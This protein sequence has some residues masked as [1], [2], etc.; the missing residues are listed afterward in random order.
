MKILL[1][2]RTGKNEKTARILAENGFQCIEIA[3][4]KLEATNAG[5]PP[6]LSLPGGANS[7]DCLIVTSAAAFEVIG[8]DFHID[9]DLRIYAVGEAS[10]RAA[11]DVG[12]RNVITGPGNASDLVQMIL[13]DAGDQKLRALYACSS[14]PAF[15]MAKA[16]EN[17]NITLV[18]WPIY[19]TVMTD[20]GHDRLRH[21]L[22]S[23]KK[24]FI[25]QYSAASAR[26][27]ADLVDHHKLVKLAKNACFVAN[28]AN[29]AEILNKAGYVNVIVAKSPSTGAMINAVQRAIESG[30]ALG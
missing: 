10:A 25:F 13:V 29:T 15:D 7:F 3:L 21:A 8:A 19:R 20:P 24:G 14:E 22:D 5:P 11:V 12:F 18:S 26:H 17:T 2:R 6:D 16:L 28:S 23:V 27:L 1:T 9:K 30:N 4:S